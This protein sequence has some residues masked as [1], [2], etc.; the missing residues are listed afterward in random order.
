MHK[1]LARLKMAMPAVLCLLLLTPALAS[2]HEHR[3]VGRYAFTV[4]FANEPALVNQP[5]AIDLRVVMPK[6]GATG[7]DAENGK[8]VEGLDK[9]LKA[10]VIQGGERMS[11]PLEAAWNDPGAYVGHFIPTKPGDYQFHFTG[12]ID[13]N[14]VDQTFESGPNRFSAVEDTSPIQFPVKVPSGTDLQQQLAD[15]QSSASQARTFGIIGIVVGA[16]GLLAAAGALLTR[17]RERSAG[18]VARTA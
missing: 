16:L 18:G 5:N 14:P 8:P 4:G 6:P 13:G 17:R 1:S 11:V 2:A 10:E 7:E 9:T 15:A 12:T 3:Q